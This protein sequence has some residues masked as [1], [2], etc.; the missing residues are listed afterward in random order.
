MNLGR[1]CSLD[2]LLIVFL[3]GLAAGAFTQ[4]HMATAGI[5][6]AAIIMRIV[7]VRLDTNP[8]AAGRPRLR[9][10]AMATGFAVIAAAF[11]MFLLG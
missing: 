4:G 7:I 10:A 11:T 5:L 3:L 6:V 1:I 9:K 2:G 8:R